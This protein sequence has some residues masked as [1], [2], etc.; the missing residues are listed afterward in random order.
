VAVALREA[1]LR[2]RGALQERDAE[3]ALTASSRRRGAR[4]SVSVARARTQPLRARA[5]GRTPSAPWLSKL[6]YA[7]SA[8]SVGHSC[9]WPAAL[10][11]ATALS[12]ARVDR[13]GKGASF[14]GE[15]RPRRR[16]HT[17]NA[18]AQHLPF[19]AMRV[20]RYTRR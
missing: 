16:A 4:V 2:H 3:H 14:S 19:V 17:S 1:L 15:R 20:P 18:P 7:S 5:S 8:R 10:A 11:D 9:T 12:M 6:S 13:S